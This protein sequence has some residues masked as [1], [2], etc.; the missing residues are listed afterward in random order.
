MRVG[1]TVGAVAI[2]VG[3]DRV[4]YEIVGF[5]EQSAQGVPAAHVVGVKVGVLENL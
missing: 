4:G 2:G 3:V 5:R 1:A